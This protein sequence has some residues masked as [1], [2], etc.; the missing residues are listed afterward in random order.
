MYNMQCVTRKLESITLIQNGRYPF[1][2]Y[3]LQDIVYD[4]TFSLEINNIIRAIES[5]YETTDNK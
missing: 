5:G 2:D 1:H 4:A 3:R